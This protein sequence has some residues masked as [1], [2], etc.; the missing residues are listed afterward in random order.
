MKFTAVFKKFPEGYAA[1]IEE[2]PGVN[3]Q[4]KTLEE[5]RKNLPEAVEL[6]L[7]TNRQLAEESMKGQDVIRESFLIPA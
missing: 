6:V 3:T 4:G 1:F 7:E 2:L 5:A